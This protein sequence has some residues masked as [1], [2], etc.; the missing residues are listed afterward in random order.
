MLGRTAPQ[1]RILRF[2]SPLGEQLLEVY[3]IYSRRNQASTQAGSDDLIYDH[4]PRRVRVQIMYIWKSSIGRYVPPS[5]YHGSPRKRNNNRAWQALHDF[6]RREKGLLQLSESPRNPRD[7]CIEYLLN[8]PNVDNVL[9]I[10]ELSF[11]II[12]ILGDFDRNDV[13]EVGITQ[14]SDDAISELNTRFKR[15]N[16]GYQFES[17]QIIRT[18]NFAMHE[19]IVKPTLLLLSDRHFAG[20]ENEFLTALKH[21]RAGNNRDAI[22]AANSAFES[23]L[24]TICKIKK[25][26]YDQRDTAG[27]LLKIVRKNGLYPDYMKTSFEQLS[28]TLQSGLTP[29]R[30]RESSS[31]GQGPELKAPPEYMT[32]YALNLCATQIRFLIK[33]MRATMK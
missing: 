4:V 32:E 23:T 17:G 3:E 13:K 14:S 16:L 15:A 21:Y 29:I 2:N 19:T 9:D 11:R 7:D 24:K 12:L 22:T 26:Q 18:D 25:W 27:R 31:H 1:R 28:G 5:R 20:A 33:S 6:V 30:N 10:V 8:E